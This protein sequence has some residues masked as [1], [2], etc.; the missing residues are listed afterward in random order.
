MLHDTLQLP[1]FTGEGNWTSSLRSRAGFSPFGREVSD[2]TYEDIQGTLTRHFL[3]MQHPYA[4]PDWL[5]TVSGNGNAPLY[6]LEVKSTTS[7]DPT[8]TF[9]MS[10]NQY[11]LVS[12]IESTSK[13]ADI[14]ANI[15]KAKKLRVTS[16]TPLEV[17]VILRVSGL[18]A[19]EN[20]ATHQPQWRVY[21]DPYSRGGE[22]VLKF[23]A[24]TYA[25][26]AAS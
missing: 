19:L 25:V 12:F 18:D 24:P 16:A 6:R 26:T 2:F 7:Q 14:C 3:Q 8:T 20:G 10:N 4:P 5:S 9:Y 15:D 22:G 13:S 21:L 23:I 11:Q 1:G 17:Y